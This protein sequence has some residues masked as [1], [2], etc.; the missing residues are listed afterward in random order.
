PPVSRATRL[1]RPGAASAVSNGMPSPSRTR[2]RKATPADSLPGG[3]V[4]SMA[5]YSRSSPIASS[6]RP[7][8]SSGP[9]PVS[10]GVRTPSSGH[11][12]P[13]SGASVDRGEQAVGDRSIV[14]DARDLVLT[15]ELPAGSHPPVE[16]ARRQ[17]PESRA[18]HTDLAEAL[19][20]VVGVEPPERLVEG[21]GE[22][23][24]RAGR[25]GTDLDQPV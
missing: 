11:R 8:Q 10:S 22:C 16:G 19:R 24:E 1:P 3:F 7:P 18:E 13:V 14:G 17:L 9:P 20:P 12:R 15:T 5:T 6:P 21:V 25:R 2:A 23:L 4:V